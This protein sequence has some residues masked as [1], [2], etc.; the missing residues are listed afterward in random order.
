MWDERVPIHM[1]SAFYDVPG[2]KA[3]RST[4]QPFEVEELGPVVNRELVHLQCHIG[5][6]TLSW[7]RLGA[8]VTGLDFSP[9]A[10]GAANELARE[11]GYPADFVCADVYEAPAALNRTFDVV[12]TGIGAL[13]W[14]Q[15]IRR[16]A[17]VVSALLRPGGHLYLVECHPLTDVFASETL[18]VEHDYFHDPEGTVW[19]APGTYAD[20]NAATQANRSIEFRHPIADVLSALLAEGLELELFHEHAHTAFARWPFLVKAP[21]GT[22][23]MPEGS[24]KLPLLYSLRARKR[25]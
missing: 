17:G 13:I 12:Y 6:D 9:A 2:F 10:T 24:P 4:L 19:D 15:D 14:L 22:Y 3:G 25:A 16:W 8:R 18:A 1:E 23:R 20:P 7:A 11:M 5:L 21:D